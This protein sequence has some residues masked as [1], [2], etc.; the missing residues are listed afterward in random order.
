MQLDDKPFGLKTLAEEV[1]TAIRPL[2]DLGQIRVRLAPSPE[3]YV[4]GDRDR[5]GEAL[6]NLL[7]NAIH[8]SEPES[9]V[10]LR[11]F[12]LC[13]C[14]TTLTARSPGRWCWPTIIPA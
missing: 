11:M 8:F 1:V 2:S 5:I 3:V 14:L 6:Y 9:E 4:R 7:D 13:F 10:E 12:V